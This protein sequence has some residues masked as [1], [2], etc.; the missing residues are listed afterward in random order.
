M[1]LEELKNRIKDISECSGDDEAAHCMEDRLYF[2][3]IKS[4]SEEKCEDIVLCCKEILKTKDI[5]FQR[6]CA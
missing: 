6:W 2:D 3:L 1:N 4:I 5:D